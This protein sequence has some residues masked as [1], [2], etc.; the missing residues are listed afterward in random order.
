MPYKDSERRRAYGRDWI[1]SNPEKAREAMRRW[2]ARHPDKHNAEARSFH[3]RHR[4]WRL[5]QQAEYRARNPAVRRAIRLRRRA[6]LQGAGG[7]F[8]AAQWLELVEA[9]GARCGYCGGPGPLYAD[10]RVPLSRGGTNS[11]D[12]IIPACGP[13]NLRKHL[14]S[15][16]EFRARFAREE[17]VM[18]PDPGAAPRPD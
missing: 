14:M 8:S 2:R 1:R 15:E 18:P 10:H 11:I 12:N 13:C 3:A 9:Y 6:R 16:S 17:R 5:Q 4:E 7:S